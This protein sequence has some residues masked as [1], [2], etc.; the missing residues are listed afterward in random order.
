M[1]IAND[2]VRTCPC[3][4]QCLAEEGCRTGTVSFVP[5][6]N[7]D[8]LPSLVCPEIC[9]VLGLTPAPRRERFFS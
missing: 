7:V 4:T 6:Q 8:D 3:S 1:V 2:R 5:Q 9:H